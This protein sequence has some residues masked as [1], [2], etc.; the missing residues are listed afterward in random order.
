MHSA[1]AG[2]INSFLRNDETLVIVPQN[3]IEFWC[4]ATRPEAANGL[5]MSLAE[6][7]QRTQ[8]FRSALVLLPDTGEIFDEWERLVTQHQ[9]A[10]KPVYDTRLVAAMLVH[11]ITHLLTFNTSDFKRY[12]EIT[13]VDP[14]SVK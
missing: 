11:G 8:A 13:V 3:V 2:S 4:V 5:G 14:A 10:G 6:T 7:A 9:V 12:N 1:A